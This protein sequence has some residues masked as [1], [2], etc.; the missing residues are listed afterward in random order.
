MET[1]QSMFEDPSN[2]SKTTMYLNKQQKILAQKVSIELVTAFG[3]TKMEQRTS[4][5]TFHALM[6]PQM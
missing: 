6:A 4:T 3:S 5:E 2:G 1:P